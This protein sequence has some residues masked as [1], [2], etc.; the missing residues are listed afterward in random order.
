MTRKDYIAIAGVL[1][2]VDFPDKPFVVD[3]LC[4]VFKKDNPRFDADRFII[5]SNRKEDKS[6]N[7]ATQSR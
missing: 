7:P 2:A 5:A 6:P 4:R 3:A 1:A